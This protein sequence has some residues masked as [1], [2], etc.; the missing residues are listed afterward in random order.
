V[1]LGKPQRTIVVE[2]IEEPAPAGG[3]QAAASAPDLIEPVAGWRLWSVLRRRDGLCLSSVARDALWPAGQGLEAR[4]R[5]HG[6]AAPQAG[7]AC[8]IHAL[9]RPGELFRCLGGLVSPPTPYVVGRVALWGR[10]VE[11][12]RGWRAEWAYPLSL[13]VVASGRDERAVDEVAAG[14]AV[15][16]CALDVVRGGVPAVLEGLERSVERAAPLLRRAR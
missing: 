11:C 6:H 16:G 13:A 1:D 5:L 7:C 2:P 10:V 14:L 3:A 15:Y 8:G 9:R 12:E 4:C